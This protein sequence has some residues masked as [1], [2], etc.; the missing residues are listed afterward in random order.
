[1]RRSVL[2]VVGLVALL[3]A[4]V[5]A[6]RAYLLHEM[7]KPVLAQL[8]DPE[9]AQFRN[10]RLFSDWSV[11]GSAMCG[12]VNAKNRMGGYTGFK[13][14][15]ALPGTAVIE[16]DLEKEARLKFGG[17]HD[18]CAFAQSPNPWWHLTF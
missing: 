6:Y 8:A 16:A 15:N 9:S 18:P 5:F 2:I 3:V 7:R 4:G 12:E 1:M 14:F 13:T 17:G 11:S 10:E